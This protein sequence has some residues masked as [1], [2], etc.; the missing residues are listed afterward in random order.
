MLTGVVRLNDRLNSGGRVISASSTTIVDGQ[1]VALLGDKVICPLDGHGE[2]YIIEACL[3]WISDNKP[4]AVD[5]CACLC[6]CYVISS[7]SDTGIG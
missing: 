2:N 3:Q 7:L 5:R 1:P 6:G 4:V